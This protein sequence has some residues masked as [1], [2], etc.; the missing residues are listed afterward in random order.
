MHVQLINETVVVLVCGKGNG[1][2]SSNQA[3]R[4]RLRAD[5]ESTLARCS[6]GRSFV[7]KCVRLTVF[8]ALCVKKVDRASVRVSA[9]WAQLARWSRAPRHCLA[10]AAAASGLSM[11]SDWQTRRATA[12]ATAH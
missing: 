1:G 7:C 12:T 3:D 6:V 4:L 2:G 10:A 5:N 9:H 8:V 11:L